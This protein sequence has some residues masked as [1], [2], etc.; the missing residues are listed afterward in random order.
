MS[1]G[2]PITR[3][4]TIGGRRISYE[5]HRSP[6]RRKSIGFH[7]EGDRLRVLAPTRTPLKHIDELVAQRESWIAERIALPRASGLRLQLE[8]GGQLPLL[9]QLHPVVAEGPFLFAF[10]G[11][12]FLIDDTDPL[13]FA[14][15]EQWFREFAY[16]EFADRVEQWSPQI[17]ATP[18]KIQVRNQK[19]RWGSAS[20]KGTLSFNWRLMFAEPEIVDYLVVHELCHLIQPDHSP[21]YWRLVESHMPDAQHW[22]RRLKEIGDSLA[23]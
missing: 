12:Q 20:S 23:W 4:A 9:G 8:H 5:I 19:T 22:R 16:E 17:G 1:C 13:R 21:A 18:A 3:K 2:Q 11:T 10:D 6:R 15:G 14:A 7:I